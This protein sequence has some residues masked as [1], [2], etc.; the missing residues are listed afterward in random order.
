[1]M[2]RLEYFLWR[3]WK[4][5]DWHL[6]IQNNWLPTRKLLFKVMWSLSTVIMVI[7]VGTKLCRH[8]M[9]ECVTASVSYV[10]FFLHFSYVKVYMLPDKTKTTKK[11][12]TFRRKTLNPQWNET[13][14]VSHINANAVKVKV[15]LHRKVQRC[16]WYLALYLA[17]YLARS[18]IRTARCPIEMRAHSKWW[19]FNK[20]TNPLVKI[21]KLHYYTLQRFHRSI[22]LNLFWHLKRT[23]REKAL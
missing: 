13:I 21:V 23:A 16:T 15:H 1:M 17:L 11:K 22:I 2:Y 12:T 20:Q 7:I 6:S 9:V 3:L 5:R 19:R 8:K 18:C 14:K 10:L 4:Q